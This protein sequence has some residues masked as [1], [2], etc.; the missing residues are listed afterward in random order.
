MLEKNYKNF[1]SGQ[2]YFE[3]IFVNDYPKETL[4]I[5]AEV[6]AGISIRVLTNEKNEGIHKSKIKGLLE[7]NG[8]YILFLDQDD[9]IMDQ[10]FVRQ[11]ETIK[12]ADIS[13]TNGL[14]RNGE[15][16]FPEHNLQR[17]EYTFETYLKDGYPLVS[18]GQA[19]IR[20]N[21]IPE[22]W[23]FNCMKQN[24][25]DDHFL[26]AIMMYKQAQININEEI[27]YIHE[28]NG[29]NA[30]FNWKQMI[31]SG[32]EFK[33]IFLNLQCLNEKQ[34]YD[35]INLIDQKV[36]KYG[37]YEELDTLWNGIPKTLLNEYFFENNYKNIAIY[38]MGIFGNRL[39]SELKKT[40]V[41]V[42]YIID[43]KVNVKNI[44]ITKVGMEENFEEV[45]AIVVTPLFDFENIKKEIVNKVPYK[46]ISLYEIIKECK[47]YVLK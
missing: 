18:L 32:L 6:P 12:K 44:D 11:V 28:E 2:I 33:E 38:G 22:E 35:F 9:T 8:E 17:K 24:G 20:K 30:S 45:D 4:V 10:Y 13:M 36:Y 23:I 42:K 1:A 39:Y 7:A 40:E 26:W 29:S 5:S 47:L 41:N 34:K 16:I 3:L 31:L 43:Q 19:L 27:L 21:A 15:P 14:Y 37:L 25:W 46:V